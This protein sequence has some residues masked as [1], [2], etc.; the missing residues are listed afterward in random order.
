M[1]QRE[2]RL[3]EAQIE[4]DEAA[5]AANGAGEGRREA[6]T[7]LSVCRFAEGAVVEE[8]ELVVAAGWLESAG[9]ED[10]DGAVEELAV[11]RCGVRRWRRSDRD[12]NAHMDVE[13][14]LAG[15]GLE[16]QHKRGL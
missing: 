6:G 12:V 10:P 16:T 15:S 8:V 7:G 14:V 4:A 11:G 1:C 2:G 9:G 13:L 5:Y 3:G